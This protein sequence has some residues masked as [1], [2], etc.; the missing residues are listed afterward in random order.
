MNNN[1]FLVS[2]NA[3]KSQSYIDRNVAGEVLTPAIQFVQDSL[4]ESMLGTRLYEKLVV[5][6]NS[7][8]ISADENANYKELLDGYIFKFMAYSVIA[9]I[10]VPNAYKTRNKG[11]VQTSDDRVSNAFMTEVKYVE[12]FYHNRADMYRLRLSDYLWGNRSKFPELV[13][14]TKWWEERA[15]HGKTKNNFYFGEKCGCKL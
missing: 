2:E 4:V 12:D 7:G 15:S 9:E 1:T 3:L 5:L 14:S 11:L 6:I 8:E 10:Q 13:A